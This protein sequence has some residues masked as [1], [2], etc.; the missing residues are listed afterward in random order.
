MLPVLELTENSAAEEK[1]HDEA[2]C[3]EKGETRLELAL[4]VSARCELACEIGIRRANI[5]YRIHS[6]R[7]SRIYFRKPAS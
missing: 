7:G 5:L 1:D 2:E 6:R 4:Q 3:S